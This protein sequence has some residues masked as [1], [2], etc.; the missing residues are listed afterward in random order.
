MAS[1]EGSGACGT[2]GR[3]EERSSSPASTAAGAKDE[4]GGDDR[5]QRTAEAAARPGATREGKG[6]RGEECLTVSWPAGGKTTANG[7]GGRREDDGD[8]RTGSRRT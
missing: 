3:R 8:G 5:R 1:A 6:K 7:D 2:E 4:G